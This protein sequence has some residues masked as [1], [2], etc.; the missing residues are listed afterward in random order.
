MIPQTHYARLG[1]ERLGTA[2]GTLRRMLVATSLVILALPGVRAADPV[3]EQPTT[4]VDPKVSI[5]PRAKPSANPT[6]TPRS[7]IRADCPTS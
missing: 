6:P 4:A 3:A 7:N 2:M 1:P 5:E